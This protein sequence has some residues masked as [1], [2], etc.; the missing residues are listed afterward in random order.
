[1]MIFKTKVSIHLYQLTGKNNM[2][3]IDVYHLSNVGESYWQHLKW[4]AYSTVIFSIMLVL[5]I[6]HGIFPF[7]LAD[8]PDK[9]MINYVKN[10]KLR[11]V[12]TGQEER[13][14]E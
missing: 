10:F 2:K 11:R 13:N 14:P 9:V 1:M 5:A 6:I 3:I 12:V 8:I 4:C 7:L